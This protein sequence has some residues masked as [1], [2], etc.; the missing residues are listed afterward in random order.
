MAVACD[1]RFCGFTPWNG[2]PVVAGFPAA[3]KLRPAPRLATVQLLGVLGG[4]PSG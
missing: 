1:R 2:T 4:L 3:D